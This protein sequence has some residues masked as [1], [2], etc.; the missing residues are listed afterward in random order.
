MS[1]YANYTWEKKAK[2]IESS[3]KRAKLNKELKYLT[4]LGKFHFNI[5][6]QTSIS[7]Y[8]YGSNDWSCPSEQL[9]SYPDESNRDG[10]LSSSNIEPSRDTRHSGQAAGQPGEQPQ[11]HVSE[12]SWREEMKTHRKGGRPEVPSLDTV[13]LTKRLSLLIFGTWH[14]VIH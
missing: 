9:T 6:K 8:S 11:C 4:F 1:L 13:A 12:S 14:C 10:E 2:N 3:G 5:S 7:L